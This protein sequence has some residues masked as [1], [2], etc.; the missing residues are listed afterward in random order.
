LRPFF[1]HL[2][3]LYKRAKLRKQRLYS[4]SADKL[5]ATVTSLL[6][7]ESAVRNVSSFYC[8]FVSGKPCSSWLWDMQQGTGKWYL[9]STLSAKALNFPASTRIRIPDPSSV[10]VLP[11]LRLLLLCC[12][13]CLDVN[14]LS[15]NYCSKSHYLNNIIIYSNNWDYSDFTQDITYRTH[16]YHST[17]VHI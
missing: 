3:D 11:L 6:L 4:A 7:A 2:Q 5:N 15:Y 17:S 16:W 12:K 13:G 9:H 14:F 8:W 1:R 10:S